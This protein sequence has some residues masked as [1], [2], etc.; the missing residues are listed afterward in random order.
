M[1]RYFWEAKYG[2]YLV[3]PIRP[4]KI[5]RNLFEKNHIIFCQLCWSSLLHGTLTEMSSDHFST[6]QWN[7]KQLHS[8]TRF[9][10]L[11][12]ASV[13]QVV[14][15][16]RSQPF[17]FKT[18]WTNVYLKKGGWN[19]HS[20]QISTMWSI[21]ERLAIIFQRKTFFSGAALLTEG[22]HAQQDHSAVQP[23]SSVSFSP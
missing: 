16:K 19:G 20:P 12:Y 15:K 23:H 13:S 5:F 3:G 22:T 7:L 14:L 10:L 21:K 6:V 17:S 2:Q 4:L 11:V 1:L 18:Q 8:W 9:F